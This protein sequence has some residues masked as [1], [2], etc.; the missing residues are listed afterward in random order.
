LLHYYPVIVAIIQLFTGSGL[1]TLVSVDESMVLLLTPMFLLSIF[2]FYFYIYSKYFDQPQPY[3]QKHQTLQ[4]FIYLISLILILATY[5]RAAIIGGLIFITILGL[6]YFRKM[7]ISILSIL[8]V[9]YLLF[10]PLNNFLKNN[11]IIIYK[12]ISYK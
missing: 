11:L 8:I 9:F 12:I 3:W 4:K 1:N 2:Y 7:T 6:I 5:T 10:F